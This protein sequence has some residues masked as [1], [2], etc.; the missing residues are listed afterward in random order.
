MKSPK[1]CRY[2]VGVICADGPDRCKRCGW[3]PVEDQRRKE[4]IDHARYEHP[5]VLL[6]YLKRRIFNHVR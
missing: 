3:N 2:N 6:A 4:W 1:E 5:E